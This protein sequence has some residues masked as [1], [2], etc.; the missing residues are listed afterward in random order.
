MSWETVRSAGHGLLELT[1]VFRSPRANWSLLVSTLLLVCSLAIGPPAKATLP[2]SSLFWSMCVST[3]D[4]QENF[5]SKERNDLAEQVGK[6]V[7]AQMESVERARKVLSAPNC[8]KANQPGFDRQLFI[9][10]SVKR[11][12]IK[13]DNHDWNLVIAGGVAGNGLFQ[14]R[15]LQPV[16]LLK[17][18]QIA[19]DE[20]IKALAE[21]VDRSVVETVRQQRQK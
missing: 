12:K 3:Y 10:L 11:Q 15:D 13:L 19:D 2:I 8:I 16:V 17:R 20:V 14:D 9:D 5:T 4:L 1:Q 7:Q 6:I 21:F 18:G